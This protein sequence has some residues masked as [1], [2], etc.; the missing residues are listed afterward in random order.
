[1]EVPMATMLTCPN[2]LDII[3]LLCT[4]ASNEP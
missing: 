1:M 2:L 3:G 4:L